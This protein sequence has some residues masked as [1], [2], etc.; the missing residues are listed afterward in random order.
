MKQG[1][2]STLHDH[3][4]GITS[5]PLTQFA[6]V[7]S[8]LIHDADH[9]GVPNSQLLEEENTLASRYKGKSVA[10]QNSVALAWNL[11]MEDRF[12]NLRAIIYVSE[13]ELM[14]FR[15]LVV[16]SVMATDIVDK[17]LKA[18]RNERWDKAFNDET[19]S[20]EDKQVSLNRKA[21]IVIEHIIQASDVAHTMQHWHVYRKW[22]ERFFKECYQAYKDGWSERNPSDYWYKGELGLFDFYIIPLTRKLKD[23]GVFGV[24]SDEYLGYAL[25]NRHQWELFGQQHVALMVEQITSSEAAFELSHLSADALEDGLFVT[26]PGQCETRASS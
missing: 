12:R 16:N 5:D 7:F 18:L 8:A 26:E 15:Q 21:T 3:T 9:P 2:G 1:R 6:C 24:S 19:P 13:E 14:R 17:E 20:N 11:L 4:Y 10:E 25:K 23:C 22:N